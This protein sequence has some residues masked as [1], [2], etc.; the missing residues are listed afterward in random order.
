MIDTHVAVRRRVVSA[1]RAG[2]EERSTVS[3]VFFPK[4]QSPV[5]QKTDKCKP[6]DIVQNT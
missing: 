2:H 4:I 3:V 5:Y 1:L 6:G